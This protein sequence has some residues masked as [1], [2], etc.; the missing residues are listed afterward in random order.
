MSCIVPVDLL[1]VQES[2]CPNEER[3]CP[4]EIEGAVHTEKKAAGSAILEACHAMKT[5]TLFRWANIGDL[6]WSCGSIA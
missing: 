4:M 1:R 5:P 3:F 6:V 2:T